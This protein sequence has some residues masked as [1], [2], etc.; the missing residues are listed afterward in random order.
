MIK[1]IINII[2]QPSLPA[3]LAPPSNSV[4]E[5]AAEPEAE[6]ESE[7]EAE[8]R[9][10]ILVEKEDDKDSLSVRLRSVDL[11]KIMIMM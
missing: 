2:L 5:P 1:T 7:P 6:P 11:I 3:P 8:V 4:E 10:L 9:L